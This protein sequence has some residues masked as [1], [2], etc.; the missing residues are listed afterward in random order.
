MT[1][2]VGVGGANKDVFQTWVGVGGAWKAIASID[3]GVSSAWKDAFFGDQIT[4]SNVNIDS[5]VVDPGTAIARYELQSDG[6]IERTVSST[7]SDIGDWITPK[8]NM[9]NYE[10]RA[11]LNSGDTPSG[12][13]LNSWLSLGTTRNWAL[14]ESGAG[15]SSSCSLNV[16]IRRASDGTVLDSATISMSALVEL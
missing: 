11:T 4:I 13:A 14:I 8:I 12:S 15:S 9:A 1:L 3:V 10:V 7:T 16:E 2:D 6:D 5:T